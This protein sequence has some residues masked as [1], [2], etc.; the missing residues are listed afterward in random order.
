MKVPHFEGYIEA[1]AI[2]TTPSFLD[3]NL[4]I[5]Y[6]FKLAQQSKL[7]LEAGVQNILNSYQQDFDKGIFRDAGYMYG[8][9]KP[10][11]FF[12]GLKMGNLL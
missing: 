7:R 8:P 10:R 1:D 3:I 11:T 2:E 4:K 12:V 6:D 5:S 9:M